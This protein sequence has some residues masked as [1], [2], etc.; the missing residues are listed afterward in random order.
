MGK[1]F[2]DNSSRGHFLGGILSGIL[3]YPKNYILSFIISLSLH[4][5]IE[6]SEINK[7]LCNKVI[8]STKNHI[9]DICFFLIGWLLATTCHLYRL[10]N[11]YFIVILW[12]IFIYYNLK[13][14]LREYLPYSSK[15]W[16]FMGVHTSQHKRNKCY[17]HKS[18]NP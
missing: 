14:L 3:I 8:E 16:L 2:L 11:I 5:L 18:I 17:I 4:L 7:N 1:H 12:F 13:E 9:G 6:C 10:F 15:N